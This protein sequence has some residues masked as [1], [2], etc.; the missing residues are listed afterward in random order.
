MERDK[1][2]VFIALSGGVDSMATG[3]LLLER[4]YH[5]EAVF[6]ITCDHFLTNRAD[7]E[8][9]A[10]A[11][12]IKLHVIDF[13]QEFRLILDYFFSQYKVGRTPNPCVYCNRFIKFGK[14]WDFARE[15]GA[16][17]LS[18]G[19]Y[20]RVIKTEAGWGIYEATNIVKDQSYVFSMINRDVPEHLV[21]PMGEYT[22]EQAKKIAGAFDTG[23]EHKEESQEICFVPEDDYVRLIEQNC[24][25]L[26]R[27]GDIVDSSGKILGKHMGM[28]KYTIGQRKG[29]GVAMGV[30]YYVTC[31]DAENNK[32][33]LGP[34]TEVM[35]NKLSASGVNW[36]IDEPAEK[37]RAKVKIRYNSRGASAK[38]CPK[39]NQVDIE[40][41]EAVSAITPGQAAVIYVED[42]HGWKVAGGAWIDSAEDI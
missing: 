35:H 27:E 32:V 24:P 34:K 5:C 20:A 25:E 3:A 6:M 1:E 12:G 39:G 16:K 36:L 21:L 9:A 31:I 2:T 22:K 10:H 40:F 26:I 38:V 13:R 19:H 37:F 30:P 18:T 28:H 8:K 14:L 29:L 41:D 23:I 4:G 33:T 17:F 15:H 11:L 42:E 7:A